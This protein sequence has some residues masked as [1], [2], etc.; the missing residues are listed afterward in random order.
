LPR[1]CPRKR[2]VSAPALRARRK[3]AWTPRRRPRASGPSRARGI[4]PSRGQMSRGEVV[5]GTAPGRGRRRP[6]RTLQPARP[7]SHDER[8]P[9]GSGWGSTLS[10]S[11]RKGSREGATGGESRRCVTLDQS[12]GS[13]SPWPVKP[14][15]VAVD[16][17]SPDGASVPSVRRRGASA[18]RS[19][20]MALP[21]P[22]AGIGRPARLRLRLSV[23]SRGGGTPEG[24]AGGARER[25]PAATSYEGRGS[26]GPAVVLAD[27][28]GCRSRR[29]AL[30][31]GLET[32]V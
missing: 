7:R 3:T 21:V 14:R 28:V 10:W 27:R 16:S 8:C 18:P 31:P 22:G 32:R 26:G 24:E 23:R 17:T 25:T 9:S 29:A 5:S 11:A 2:H 30:G 20:S 1:M 19:G 4:C 12:F 15:L 6:R 13:S